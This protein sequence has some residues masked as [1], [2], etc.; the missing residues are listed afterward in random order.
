MSR[1][2]S[3]EYY[4]IDFHLAIDAIKYR[5]YYLTEKVK[6]LY[7]VSIERKDYYCPQ[8]KAQWTQLEVLDRVG[9]MGFEC[10]RCSGILE[11]V[12]QKEG[13][14][15]GH[16]KQSRLMSQLE[17]FLKMLQQIDDQIIPKND[18]DTAIAHAIPLQRDQALNPL[19]PYQA[20]AHHEK[21]NK[22]VKQNV[23]APLDVSLTSLPERTAHDVAEAAKRKAEIAVQ[24]SLPVWHT[25]STVTG[26]SN[27][28]VA[29]GATG[30]STAQNL[31]NGTSG[32]SKEGVQLNDELTAY[33]AQ[34]AREKELEARE[35]Q[36]G[37]G[38]SDEA[39]EDGFEDVSLAHVSLAP[40]KMEEKTSLGSA[41]KQV[42]SQSPRPEP[43]PKR[44]RIDAGPH[45]IKEEPKTEANDVESEEDGADFEDI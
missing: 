35:D 44:V 16:E 23:A 28:I 20:V 15:T 26:Q 25:T 33:Y 4:Y 10:H 34:L 6:D 42:S 2:I 7:K 45:F 40:I 12:E 41:L 17:R 29:N 38:S 36:A 27:P 37:D 5:V 14:A 30:S 9:P 39:D 19:R 11:R 22:I 3:K 8:C 31:L 32:D 24:N 21:S 1:P 13:E 43:S 18:F